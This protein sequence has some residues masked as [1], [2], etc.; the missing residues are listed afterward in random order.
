MGDILIPGWLVF[1]LPVM[2]T[3]GMFLGLWIKRDDYQDG[4]W[5][6]GKKERASLRHLGTWQ[7]DGKGCPDDFPDG[8]CMHCGAARN[9]PHRP[10]CDHGLPDG[11]LLPELPDWTGEQLRALAEEPGETTGP[12][13]ITDLDGL[14]ERIRRPVLAAVQLGPSFTS[15]PLPT[16]AELEQEWSWGKVAWQI[17]D[18]RRFVDQMPEGIAA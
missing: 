14:D 1:S 18:L 13:T 11:E 5:D 6:G 15:L 9:E 17:V 8:T 10:G 16:Q 2:F 3:A 12:F 4:Y 7:D